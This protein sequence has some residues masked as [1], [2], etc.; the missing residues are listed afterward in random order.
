MDSAPIR[1]GEHCFIGPSCGMYTAVH[2][3]IAEERDRGL[4]KALP[5]TVGDHVWF[6]GDVTVLPGV[7]I[8]SYSVIGAGSVVTKDIPSGVIAA[9][10]PCRVLRKV[11]EEDRCRITG[12]ERGIFHN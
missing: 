12:E 6:G 4:E 10:N 1:I 3:L 2:P 7:T 9:G 11:T 8:G 5:I